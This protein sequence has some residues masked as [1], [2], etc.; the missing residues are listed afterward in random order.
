MCEVF[1]S[2]LD[3]TASFPHQNCLPG[4]LE[5]EPLLTARSDKGFGMIRP[6]TTVWLTR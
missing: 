3:N 4:I 5:S 2:F 1:E 6:G